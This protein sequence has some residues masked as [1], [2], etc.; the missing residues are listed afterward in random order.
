M[1]F[2]KPDEAYHDYA[3]VRAGLAAVVQ[4]HPDLA[5]LVELG[6]SHKGLSITGLRLN[7][8]AKGSEPSSKPGAFFLGTH[9]AREHLSSE[10]PL[11]AAQWL[12][13]NR[14]KPEVRS[15]LETRDVYF[16]PLLN[17]DGSEYDVE[18]GDYRWQR[19]NLS[20]NA[21]GTVGTDL[22]RNYDHHWG[23]S[24]SSR[25]PGDDTYRG[26]GPFSEPES[27]AVR[28]FVLARPNLKTMVSYHTYSELIL[29]PWS[30]TDQPLPAGPPLK[31]FQAM[32]RKMA[33]W[34]GYTPQQ[35]SDL[36]AS[37]GDTCD[38]AWEARGIYCFTFELTPRSG[39]GGGFYPGAGVIAPTVAKTSRPSSTSSAW[40]TIPAAAAGPTRGR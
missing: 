1:G 23:E 29:Y 30:Y 40:R 4:A 9:H 3:E 37:S 33:Q 7:T 34:T 17:P 21:D 8:T 11:L 16:V 32:A 13:E 27:R 5:S 12:A 19:K 28:D 20:P 15:L 22:N 31:A 35:S 6:R 39:S 26:T 24:G 25:S 38:W 10:V 2:P 14:A 36:Y 18:D